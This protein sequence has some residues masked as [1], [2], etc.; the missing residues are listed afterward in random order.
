MVDD[1]FLKTRFD[2]VIA[3][4]LNF[5]TRDRNFLPHDRNFATHDRNFLPHDR[6][7]ATHDRKFT[8]NDRNF[9]THGRNFLPHDRNFATHGRKFIAY[10]RNFK[11]RIG[12]F[13]AHILIRKFHDT[14]LQPFLPRCT[15]TG[16]PVLYCLCTVKNEE[17]EKS[18]QRT[19]PSW[20]A[21]T[22]IAP[23]TLQQNFLCMS[24]QWLRTV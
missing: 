20:R 15:I 22:I 1:F 14:K 5:T 21:A 13:C 11:I 17:R 7:F 16:V 2:I 3:Y 23:L 18:R 19:M 12:N 4:I 8:A 9:A 24:A 6:N 10:D